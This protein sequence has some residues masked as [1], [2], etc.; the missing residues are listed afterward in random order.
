MVV[1]TLTAKPVPLICNGVRPDETPVVGEMARR[2]GADVYVYVR[3]C[4]EVPECVVTVT[5]TAPSE[6][7]IDVNVI[8]LSLTT[9]N[10]STDTDPK[11]TDVAPVK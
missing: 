8:V 10:V 3:G 1:P 4:V 6:P 11:K 9:V 7:G 5:C 2:V